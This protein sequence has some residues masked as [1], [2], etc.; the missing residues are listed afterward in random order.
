MTKPIMSVLAL[1][2]LA[3]F[4][5]SADARPE[6]AAKEKKDCSF[7]H[8][9]PS[10]GGERN[11][12]GQY[13]AKNK[14]SLVGLPIAFK[15]AWK[16]EAPE[17][18]RRVAVGDVM[19]DKKPRV[20]VLD[21]TDEVAVMSI[22]E[23]KL[24]KDAGVKLGPK[25]GSFF[26]GNF[27]KGKPAVIAT[28]GAVHFRSGDAF[29]SKPA[30]E[31]SNITGTVRFEDGEECVFI[32]D[33]MEEPAVFGVDS[34]KTN[35]LTV[36]RGMVLPDQGAGIYASVVARLTPDM[37]AMLGFPEQVQ[38]AGVFGLWDPRSDGSLFAW[39]PW[40]DANGT[41]LVFFDPGAVMGGGSL[42]PV[43]QSE[44]LAGKV[45]DAAVG[46]DPKDGKTPGILLLMAT[47]EGGKGRTLE[48]LALD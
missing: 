22:A 31:L 16:L 21:T 27:E 45:L 1:V 30:P 34:T 13:Y 46:K 40:T 38:Q 35:P 25:A 17:G 43:W 24:T 3:T 47:G 23:S 33:S 37:V 19:G 2:A 18:A 42:K 11:S 10:G 32:F 7:C 44:K 14:Y 12:R 8:I 28:P 41:K 26:V 36:G 48:F 20:L 15:S 6:Y 39:A 5:G 4:V 29:A 9:N